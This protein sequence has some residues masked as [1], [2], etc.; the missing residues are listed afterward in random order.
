MLNK[1]SGQAGVDILVLHFRHY[2]S[3]PENSHH[4][5]LDIKIKRIGWKHFKS[6]MSS[7]LPSI[8]CNYLSLPSLKIPQKIC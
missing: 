6:S 8:M 1:E 5:N 3:N 4:Q 2:K 7:F